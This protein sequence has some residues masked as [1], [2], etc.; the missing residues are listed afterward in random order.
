MMCPAPQQDSTGLPIKCREIS[1]MDNVLLSE[2]FKK[3]EVHLDSSTLHLV[4][5]YYL[6]VW[7]FLKRYYLPIEPTYIRFCAGPFAN[8]F[9]SWT[10]PTSQKLKHTALL[11]VLIQ[12]QDAQSTKKKWN[13]QHDEKDN[14]AV[15]TKH[16]WVPN[17]FT[18][19][20]DNLSHI[21]HTKYLQQKYLCQVVSC[22]KGWFSTTV[23]SL[24]LFS[25]IS[26]G[27]FFYWSV[28]TNASNSSM[29]F[30]YTASFSGRESCRWQK[31]SPNLVMFDLLL[32]VKSKR[33]V[34][35]SS[36]IDWELMSSVRLASCGGFWNSL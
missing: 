7:F 15:V 11:R 27:Q 9:K 8:K 2:C 20:S 31:Q 13:Y 19:T 1:L 24:H 21:W 35:R 10:A 17:K 25:K 26:P 16:Q 23:F 3:K 6:E 30:S 4:K 5:I 34:T 36:A 33:C 22:D 18:S 12:S 32:I 14:I 29:F 28:S